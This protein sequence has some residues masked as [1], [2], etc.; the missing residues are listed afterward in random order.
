[1]LLAIP[2]L[3][4]FFVYNSKGTYFFMASTE[5][6]RTAQST[7]GLDRPHPPPPPKS[8]IRNWLRAWW[9]AVLWAAIISFLSTDS[10]SSAHTSRIIEPLLRWVFPSIS[11][12]TLDLL[13]HVIRKCAHFAEYFVFGLLLYH[14]FRASHRESRP[15]HWSWAVIAWLIAVCYSV[16]DE[17]HQ[18]FVPSR[19]PSA[20]DSLL[21][22]TAALCALI[23]L[24]FLYR[25]FLG[26]RTD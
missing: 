12:G 20:W 16:L 22:S 1:L 9:P 6:W 26:S 23:L 10:F 3:H 14:G 19:G 18:I 13:H 7:T 15:W 4:S 21:D 8:S 2:A 11:A 24:F 25:R 17:V 5:S